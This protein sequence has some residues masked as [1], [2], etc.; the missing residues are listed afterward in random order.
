MTRTRVTFDELRRKTKRSENVRKGWVER[1]APKGMHTYC[2]CP[3]PTEVTNDGMA[4]RVFGT[5]QCAR[6]ARAVF[7]ANRQAVRA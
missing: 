1:K 2:V 6:C 3:K 7:D 5:V 4:L